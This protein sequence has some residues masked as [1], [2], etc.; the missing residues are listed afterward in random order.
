MDQDESAGLS[1]IADRAVAETLSSSA[2]FAYQ[3]YIRS[4]GGNDINMAVDLARLSVQ[5][6]S[7]GEK[8]LPD[9]LNNLG[10]MLEGRY[11]RTGQNADLEEAIR[12]AQRAVVST[13]DHTKRATCLNN[14]GSKLGQYYSKMGNL[15]DLEEAIRK[16]REAIDTTS[17]NHPHHADFLHNLGNE[18]SRRYERTGEIADLEEA[19]QKTRQAVDSTPE[20]HLDRSISLNSLGNRLFLRY[21]R[22]GQITDLED[23]IHLAQQAV[24]ITPEGHP[25]HVARLESL[26]LKLEYRYEQFGEMKDLDQAIKVTEQAMNSLPQDHP[27]RLVFLS[28]LGNKLGR[29]YERT[30]D[31]P[32]LEKAIKLIRQAVGCAAEDNPFRSNYLNNLGKLLGQRYLRTEELAD[33]KEAIERTR[34]SVTLTAT[35][36][37]DHAKR[38]SNLA[39]KLFLLNQR[40]KDMGDLDDAINAAQQAVDSTPRDHPDLAGRLNNLG[41]KLEARYMQGASTA[42]LERASEALHNAWNCLTAVPLTRVKAAARCLKL[43]ATQE[44][45]ELAAKLGKEIIDLLPSIQTNLLDRK[46]QQFAVSTFT[47]V[48]TDLCACL[49]ELNMPDD[50]LRYLEHGRACIIGQ[51]ID[52]RR[53][54]SSLARKDHTIAQRYQNLLSEINTPLRDVEPSAAGAQVLKRRREHVAEMDECIRQIRSIE[55]FEHFMLGQSIAEMQECASEGSIILVNITPFRS[56]AIIVSRTAIK[57]VSLPKLSTADTTAWLSGLRDEL[58]RTQPE[59]KVDEYRSWSFAKCA[60]RNAK[61]LRVTKKDNNRLSRF[62]ARLWSECVCLVLEELGCGNPSPGQELPRVWWIGTGL[63]SSLPF[64]A[65]ADSSMGPTC[66]TLSRV[67]S[68]YTPTIKA[69]RHARTREATRVEKHSVLLV[70]MPKTPGYNDLPAVYAEESAI[71]AA[72]RDLHPIEPLMHPSKSAVLAKLANHSLIHFACHGSSDLTDSSGSYLALQG[73]SDSAPEK[74]TVQEVLETNL[75]NAWLAYLSACST[76]ENKVLELVDEDLHLASSFQ[77]AGF[78]HVVASMWPSNDAICA[79][80]ASIF[81]QGLVT[82]DGIQ[83]DDRAVAASLHAAVWN[84]RLK[85]IERPYL[86]AQYIH[87]GA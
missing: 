23:A 40:T 46:D 48:A 26:G 47:G 67:I 27:F 85:N 29:R 70:A 69:L 11:K 37:P 20:N 81:Y 6:T 41:V 43:L 15:A 17:A 76:A 19:I 21:K 2:I 84:I 4:G 78:R 87:F 44:K 24:D 57:T 28:N 8:S 71:R 32:E 3:R 64:H 1:A 33:L 75:G 5:K 30:R 52:R 82:K 45:F 60:S 22:K 66:N 34:Q 35:G 13:E 53:D 18:L 59:M 10:V 74:L 38:L 56:D 72:I 25:E 14:L 68:S 80:V 63:A 73:R 54:I 55:G 42:D 39:N 12:V 58:P 65:A 61:L 77:A 31:E 51:L 49:L 83:G 16:I 79:Q 86:W 7:N 62:L 50:A 36:H 9:R